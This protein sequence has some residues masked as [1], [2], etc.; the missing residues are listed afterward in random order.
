MR[1]RTLLHLVVIGFVILAGTRVRADDKDDLDHDRSDYSDIKD[2]LNS[3]AD[4]KAKYLEHSVSLRR[5]DKD[6]LN[7]LITQ[8]C[9]LDIP[10]DDDAAMQTAV[11]LRDKVVDQVN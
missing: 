2:R 4:K 1:A 9:A 10:R 6:Q 11:S 5:M 7:T 8:I 3:A